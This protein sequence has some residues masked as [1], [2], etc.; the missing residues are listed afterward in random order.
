M[1]KYNHMKSI[2]FSELADEEIERMVTRKNIY[3]KK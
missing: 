2:A 1:S 3:K